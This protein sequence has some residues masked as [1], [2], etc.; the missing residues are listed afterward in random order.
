MDNFISSNYIRNGIFLIPKNESNNFKKWIVNINLQEKKN[1]YQF[2]NALKILS[3]N[4]Y[5]IQYLQ[6]FN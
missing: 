6:K 2:E 1:D 4:K 3:K 5:L